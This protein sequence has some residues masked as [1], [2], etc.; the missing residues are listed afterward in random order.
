[1][2]M[3]CRVTASTLCWF[4]QLQVAANP[5]SLYQGIFLVQGLF[6]IDTEAATVI[7]FL[8]LGG[9]F[10][11]I[12]FS[13]VFQAQQ[14]VRLGHDHTINILLLPPQSC[15]GIHADFLKAWPSSCHHCKEMD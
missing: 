2:G 3:D 13:E 1:M 10:S 14:K 9:V 11:A 12:G 8:V 7:L 4:C 6:L 5:L 15:P